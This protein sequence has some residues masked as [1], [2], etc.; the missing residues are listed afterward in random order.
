MPYSIC[1][2]PYAIS[3]I[4]YIMY[5]LVPYFS[6]WDLRF[7]G[8]FVMGFENP[9]PSLTYTPINPL[10]KYGI[11]KNPALNRALDGVPSGNRG[12]TFARYTLIVGRVKRQ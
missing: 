2:I 4:R 6:N 5:R 12:C 9:P 10:L 1:H 7:F 11:H 3:H 8:G